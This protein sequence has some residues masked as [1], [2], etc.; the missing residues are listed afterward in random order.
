[1]QAGMRDFLI[2]YDKSSSCSGMRGPFA[3]YDGR[4]S[5]A[6]QPG[7]YYE[8]FVRGDMLKAWFWEERL[9]GV[10]VISMPTVAGDGARPLRELIV[11]KSRKSEADLNWEALGDFAA[12]Q[13]L[14]LDEVL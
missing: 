7:G 2:K 13:G 3:G 9:V 5:Q 8:Q 4:P 1:P 14:S 6:I 11:R 12:Y 10:D